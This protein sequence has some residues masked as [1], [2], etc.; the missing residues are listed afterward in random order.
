MCKV[1]SEQLPLHKGQAHK[2]KKEGLMG[3]L[4]QLVG[5]LWREKSGQEV[6]TPDMELEALLNALQESH[7]RFSLMY[8]SWIPKPNKP[9]ELR[10][11]TQPAKKDI[12]VMDDIS[13]LLNKVYAEIFLETSHGSR[14][15]CGPITFF[16]NFHGWGP[17]DRLIKSDI[18][19]CFDNIDH[20]L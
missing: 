8:R 6:S 12:I 13:Y 5:N 15:G 11:I 19:K 17:I 9:G 14:K 4:V 10:P 3:Q 2:S 18:V 7:F 1:Y 16:S 20:R